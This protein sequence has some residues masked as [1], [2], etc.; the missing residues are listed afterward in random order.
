MRQKLGELP[1]LVKTLQ[2]REQHEAAHTCVTRAVPPYVSDD[3]SM[4]GKRTGLLGWRARTAAAEERAQVGGILPEVGHHEQHQSPAQHEPA[5]RHGNPV[6]TRHE[7]VEAHRRLAAPDFSRT[8]DLRLSTLRP[9]PLLRA[10]HTS[11]IL[12]QDGGFPAGLQAPPPFCFSR[13]SRALGPY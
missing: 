13:P 7:T 10:T 12:P 4:T 9:C 1:L 5:R 2:P 11:K 8:A 3:C 6:H